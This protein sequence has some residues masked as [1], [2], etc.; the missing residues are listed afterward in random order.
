MVMQ[1]SVLWNGCFSAFSVDGLIKGDIVVAVFLGDLRKIFAVVLRIQDVGSQQDI[2]VDTCQRDAGV[3]QHDHRPFAVVHNFMGSGIFSPF[4][5][6]IT[7]QHCF[8]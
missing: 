4:L 5:E 1:H 3:M 7:C 6:N 2:K 8:Q